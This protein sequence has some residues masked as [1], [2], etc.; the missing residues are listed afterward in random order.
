MFRKLLRRRPE[1]SYNS[2]MGN[3]QVQSSR[4]QCASLLPT[5]AHSNKPDT[6]TSGVGFFNAR[7]LLATGCPSGEARLLQRTFATH[8]WGEN[9]GSHQKAAR[10]NAACTRRRI[11]LRWRF[12]STGS[13][14]G[15]CG[16]VYKS[17]ALSAT[18][19]QRG[20]VLVQMH[21]LT[22]AVGHY[23]S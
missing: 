2:S 15:Y 6:A 14:P 10:S 18:S 5:T 22:V 13:P 3:K 17:P 7:S 16:C 9:G 11:S 4:S 8:R 23:W 20:V 12:D 19:Q 1:L 21:R